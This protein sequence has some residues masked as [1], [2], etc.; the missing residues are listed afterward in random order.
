M[1]SES[2]SPDE[3][4]EILQSNWLKIMGAVLLVLIVALSTGCADRTGTDAL[5]GGGAGAGAGLLLGG[6][7]GAIAGGLLGGAGGALVG[8]LSKGGNG[9]GGHH[10]YHPRRRHR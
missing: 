8:E 5:I 9:D 3:D 4:L 1:T 6:P 2:H 10:G 7:E